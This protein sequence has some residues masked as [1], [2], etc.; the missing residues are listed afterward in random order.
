MSILFFLKSGYY[1]KFNFRLLSDLRDPRFEVPAKSN[2]ESELNQASNNA[3]RCESELNQASN[4]AKRLLAICQADL[5]NPDVVD[6]NIAYYAHLEA[7]EEAYKILTQSVSEAIQKITQEG[8]EQGR[9]TNLQTA[10]DLID[11]I[12]RELPHIKV[13]MLTKV[14]KQNLTVCK[15]DLSKPNVDQYGLLYFTHLKALEEAYEI[16]TQSVSE[17]IQKITQKG[18]EQGRQT[19]LQTAEAL[20]DQIGG[21]LPY[22]KVGMLTKIAE[23]WLQFVK[24]WSDA[25]KE[26]N[27]QPRHLVFLYKCLT[28]LK[29]AITELTQAVTKAKEATQKKLVPEEQTNLYLQ[30]A[31]TVIAEA[32]TTIAEAN[33]ILKSQSSETQ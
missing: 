21:E 32:N 19:N 14:V 20:I 17:V 3:K 9:Q 16:L 27:N 5:N 7:L 33:E 8:A 15:E 4:N 10:K 25:C 22:I 29:D 26:Y 1:N 18:A 6:R 23:K 12:D 24:E 28:P 2:S 30:A 11:Q 13:G 31:E